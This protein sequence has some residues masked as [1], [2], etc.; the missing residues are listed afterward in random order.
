MQT[1]PTIKCAK[2]A[3]DNNINNKYALKIKWSEQS[4]S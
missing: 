2:I 1:E 3:I 4:G